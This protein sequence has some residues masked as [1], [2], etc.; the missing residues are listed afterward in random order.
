MKYLNLM[1]TLTATIVLTMPASAQVTSQLQCKSQPVVTASVLADSLCV[2]VGQSEEGDEVR[3]GNFLRVVG[4]SSSF[5][6][7]KELTGHS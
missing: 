4:Q 2:R 5:G 7:A 1:S 3:G 6:V